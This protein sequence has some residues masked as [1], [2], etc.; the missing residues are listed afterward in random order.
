[1][2][3]SIGN[4]GKTRLFLILI[5]VTAATGAG[6]AGILD[7]VI[8]DDMNAGSFA[9]GAIRGLMVGAILWTF[10]LFLMDGP[11]G[12][13]L[14]RAPFAVVLAIKTVSSTLVLV[15][16]IVLSRAVLSHRGHSMDQWFQ[17]GFL[18]DTLMAL[19]VMLILH[20]VLQ[21][22]RVIG[23]RVLWNLVIG[24]YFRPVSE[25]RIFMFL[26]VAESTALAQKMG[27]L[28]VHSLLSRFFRD[29]A[30]PI[31]AHGGE[32]HRYVGDQVVVTWPMDEGLR[33]AR[34]LRCVFAV[35]DHVAKLAPTYEK[36]FGAA[37]AFRVG[38]H[39]GQVVAGECG[40]EKLE[41]VYF[42]DTVNLAA[43]LQT[44]CRGLGC[45]LL[46]SGELM[47]RMNLPPGFQAKS[48]GSMVLSGRDK[49][50]DVYTVEN[51]DR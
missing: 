22:R 37:P 33:D 30:E 9:R 24:S 29:I 12:W 4:Q 1:M 20:F 40:D 17:I 44:A 41:I 18:R 27:D 28:G 47:S 2:V 21:A 23:G 36:I 13:P 5:L 46:V 43:R 3:A 32:T 25:S 16:A 26:D 10:E 14:R 15:S 19:A 39:G 50:T 49:A 45:D 35:R 38:L 7:Q 51:N 34:C 11:F 48:L 6:Y 31:R 42:G 8:R